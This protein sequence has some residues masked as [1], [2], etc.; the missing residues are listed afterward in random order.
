MS[1]TKKAV[2][3]RGS[4]ED[5]T[6]ERKILGDSADSWS[7]GT[8]AVA[9]S[10]PNFDHVGALCIAISVVSTSFSRPL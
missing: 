1:E 8:L 10:E 9:V 5:G 7:S 2:R 3:K 6:L 4:R